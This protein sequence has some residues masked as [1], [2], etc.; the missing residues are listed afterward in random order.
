MM[1][2][3]QKESILLVGATPASDEA[4]ATLTVE[5]W[6]LTTLHEKMKRYKILPGLIPPRD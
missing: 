5:S 2:I 6:Y 1:P 3:V 4:A